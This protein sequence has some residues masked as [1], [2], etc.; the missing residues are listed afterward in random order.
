MN[1]RAWLLSL[2]FSLILLPL[3][4]D[5][6]AASLEKIKFPYSPIAWN[7]LPW[8]MAK[9]AGFFEKQGLDVDMYYEGASSAI[10]QA[11]L[12]GEA[13]FAGLAGPAVVANVIN[14]GDVIQVAAV[15]KTFTIPMYS[16]SA[17]KE[18]SQLK[19]QKVGV[20]RFG[21][22]SH[23]AALNI[24]QRA[25]VTGVTIIQTGGIPES[26]A[27]LMSGNVAAAMVPPPQSVM[28]REKGFRELVSVKQFR[29]WNIPVVENGIAARRS[30][31]D[32]NPNVVKGFIRAAFE[33]I[34]RIY[35]NKESTM[36]ILAKYTKLTDEKLLDESYRFSLEA[37]SKD[38]AMPAEAF[39]ALVDQMVSQKS[40][41]TGAAKKLPLSAYYD[42]RYVDE[43]EKEGFFKKLWQ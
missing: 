3:S 18:V 40:I 7:S 8:W 36:K 30:Y 43:L 33:G 37:L 29:E 28:L 25:G 22:I 15:V 2:L 12:A 42:N 27:A 9:D 26:T 34:R 6:R 19:G 39:A 17:I 10:V 21:S 16:Q 13:N 31:A 38:G 5:S 23:I 14:G 1:G 11:M 35:D 24:L 32:K 41:D 4:I 20:S